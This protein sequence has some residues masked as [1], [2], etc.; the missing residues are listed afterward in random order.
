MQTCREVRDNLAA[1]QDGEMAEEER[2]A[3]EAHLRLCDACRCE[4]EAL[5]ALRRRLKA[6]RREDANLPLPAHVWD[7]AAR[8]WQQQDARGRGRFPVRLALIT[9]CL[10]LVA[11]G[12][13]FA[14]WKRAADFPAQAV[15]DDFRQVRRQASARPAFPTANAAAA[16]NWLRVQLRSEIPSLDLSSSQARLLGADALMLRGLPVGRLLYRSQGRLIAVYLARRATHFPRLF[17]ASIEGRAFAVSGDAP[18]MGFYG[19]QQ[20]ALGYGLL[21]APPLSSGPAFAL[22]AQRASE[23]P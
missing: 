19:W 17:A 1:Y 14:Q 21:L 22:N 6:L 9:V 16:A 4:A 18:D 11:Y 12:A 2:A 5:A 7:N 8:A 10:Y 13:V 15:T 20:G 3:I 23:Q